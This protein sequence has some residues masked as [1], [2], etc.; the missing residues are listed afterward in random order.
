MNMKRLFFV[1]ALLLLSLSLHSQTA[2]EDYRLYASGNST[3]ML[4]LRG[5]QGMKFPL[6]HNGTHYWYTPEFISGSLY[7]NKKEYDGVFLNIDAFNQELVIAEM[8]TRTNIL[9]VREYVERFTIGDR[10]Y[11][12]LNACGC[13]SAPAGY[14]E[15]VYDG[16]AKFYLRIDKTL[17]TD[18][19]EKRWASAGYQGNLRKGVHDIF[20]ENRSYYYQG[21]DGT[22]VR[23][24][25]RNALL[26]IYAQRRKDILRHMKAVGKQDVRDI[27][28][29]AAEVLK[30]VEG[31]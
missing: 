13:P 24:S 17:E 3:G 5:R 31:R 6:P 27:C 7:Y 29:Y 4:V 8:H 22:L 12:N 11:V 1:A 18:M 28:E 25:G 19:E 23:I 16:S 9:L 20:I 10:K 15:L 14:F 21:E 30:Y 26:K 2:G